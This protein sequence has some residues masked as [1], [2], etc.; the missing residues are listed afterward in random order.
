MPCCQVVWYG[1]GVAADGPLHVHWAEQPAATSCAGHCR[2][3]GWSSQAAT[4]CAGRLTGIPHMRLSLQVMEAAGKHQV[5]IFVH[6]RKE[7]AKTAR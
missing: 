2:C 6:S 4:S 1:T 3:N 5:L 7:T